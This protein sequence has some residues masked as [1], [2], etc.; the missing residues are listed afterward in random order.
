MANKK[1]SIKKWFEK[2]NEL[3]IEFLKSSF[4]NR[5]LVLDDK[6]VCNLPDSPPLPEYLELSCILAGTAV[7]L[8]DFFGY[9]TVKLLHDEEMF[10]KLKQDYRIFKFNQK[11]KAQKKVKLQF[12]VDKKTFDKLENIKSESEF[13]SMGSCVK[14]LIDQN[15]SNIKKLKERVESLNKNLKELETLKS[16]IEQYN[17]DLV[18]EINVLKARSKGLKNSIAQY[19]EKKLF[20]KLEYHLQSAMRELVS[21]DQFKI[22]DVEPLTKLIMEQLRPEV[23]QDIKMEGFIDQDESGI[24]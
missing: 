10:E 23:L 22:T 21:S 3:K 11:N 4:E 20:E 16:K 1:L 7:V 12:Y 5:K 17:C 9:P 14:C 13:S 6:G 18:A 8:K 24:T 2:E 19:H 15:T